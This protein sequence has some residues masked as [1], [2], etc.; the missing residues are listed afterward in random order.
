MVHRFCDLLHSGSALIMDL[1][2]VLLVSEA[3]PC[4]GSLVANPS[5]Q[6]QDLPLISL[7]LF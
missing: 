1:F 6:N 3:L 2:F 4:Y 5:T 7:G